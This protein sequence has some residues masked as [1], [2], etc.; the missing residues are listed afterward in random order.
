MYCIFYH[1][2]CPLPTPPRAPSPLYPPTFMFFLSFNTTPIKPN[3]DQQNPSKTKIP[4][5]IKKPTK[6]KDLFLC[7]S[8]P[9]V[10]GP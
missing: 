5:Q 9:P 6:N 8:D 10:H 7:W 2:I 4:S 3:Q 1:F